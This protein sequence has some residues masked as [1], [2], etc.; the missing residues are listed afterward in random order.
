MTAGDAVASQSTSDR[1]L[2]IRKIARS[3][4]HANQVQH[5]TWHILPKLVLF[6]TLKTFIP[7]KQIFIFIFPQK[8]AICKYS[9][10]DNEVLLPAADLFPPLCV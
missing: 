6:L 4:F 9:V 3:L 2:A 10:F 5:R 1:R 7:S 8:A